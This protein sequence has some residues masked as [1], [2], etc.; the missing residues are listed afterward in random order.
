MRTPQIS[1]TEILAFSYSPDSLPGLYLSFSL[2]CRDNTNKKY[3][4]TGDRDIDPLENG[5]SGASLYAGYLNTR[6][7]GRTSALFSME[8]V[9]TK[10]YRELFDTLQENISRYHRDKA[11][12]PIHF[13][14]EASKRSNSFQVDFDRVV[15]LRNVRNTETS[16]NSLLLCDHL[17]RIIY[18]LTHLENT[19]I[20]D[21]MISSFSMVSMKTERDD[22]YQNPKIS[23]VQCHWDRFPDCWQRVSRMNH[24]LPSALLDAFIQFNNDRKTMSSVLEKQ[25]SVSTAHSQ[26]S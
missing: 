18:Q 23:P 14:V 20:R 11:L 26:P 13:L 25:T 15:G 19:E 22:E 8:A 9:E 3:G 6:S 7:G 21:I 10:I 24:L 5:E 17:L 4:V 12:I 1:T 2:L 16:D